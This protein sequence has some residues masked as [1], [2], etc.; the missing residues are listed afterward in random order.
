MPLPVNSRFIGVTALGARVARAVDFASRG[1]VWA[2]LAKPTAWLGTDPLSSPPNQPISDLIPPIPNPISAALSEPVVAVKATCLLVVPDNVNGTVEAYGMKWRV[3]TPNNASAEGCRWVLVNASF[4]YNTAP[5]RQ[6]DS[7][8]A[9]DAAAGDTV[10]HLHYAGGYQVG[11]S[12]IIGG[13][14][15]QQS[16]VTAVK[17]HDV[18]RVG[19]NATNT[20]LVS[21]G[22]AP[23]VTG[24]YALT[25]KAGTNPGTYKFEFGAAGATDNV[26]WANGLAVSVT[27]EGAGGTLTVSLNASAPT[28]LP[29]S[30]TVHVTANV[31]TI[32]IADALLAAD[33]AG[34]Y[35]TNLS[36]PTAFQYRQVGVLSHVTFPAQAK[37][38]QRTVPAEWLTDGYL[39]WYYNDQPVPRRLNGRDN[40]LL[41][42]TF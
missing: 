19:A 6:V 16:S 1:D 24:D 12:V 14:N 13:V 40:I 37:P 2:V 21:A 35:V 4:D 36:Y 29:V 8:L 42:L 25:V 30:D 31:N 27:D 33:D 23:A 7:Y 5:I 11:D 39:E 15:G 41:V 28:T 9:Q 38:G 20:T 17:V 22:P 26:V 34:N 18:Y 10:L 32:T 3:V